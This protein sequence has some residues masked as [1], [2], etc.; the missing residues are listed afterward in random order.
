[1]PTCWHPAVLFGGI[2]VGLL[3]GFLWEWMREH[4]HR[5]AAAERKAELRRLERELL[6]GDREDKRY[7]TGSAKRA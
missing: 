2:V 3:I 4:K 5:A 1:M 6:V 7:P